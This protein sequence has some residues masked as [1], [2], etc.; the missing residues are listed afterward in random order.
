[1]GSFDINLKGKKI[2]NICKMIS[3]SL[4]VINKEEYILSIFT[5]E[6]KEGKLNDVLFE[7][8]EMKKDEVEVV[9]PPHITK[10]NHIFNTDKDIKKRQ[11]SSQKIL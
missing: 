8:K 10:S 6:I 2:K 5:A 3:S 9:V 7:I 1:M 11:I 4:R